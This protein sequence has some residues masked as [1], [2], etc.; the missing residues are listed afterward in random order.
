MAFQR[1]ILR[2]GF[3]ID[4]D[5][6]GFSCDLPRSAFINAIFIRLY[7]TGG[8]TGVALKDIITKVN[9]KAAAESETYMDLDADEIRLRTK[10]L[11]SLEP[12]VNDNDNADSWID[13]LLLFGRKIK[14]KR[15]MLDAAKHG[16]LQLS[17][18][19]GTLIDA[20]AFATG[21]VQ[22]D[23]ELIQWVGARPGEYAGCIKSTHWRTKPTGTGWEDIELPKGN[24]F[25][26]ISFV[27]GTATTINEV[28]FG[29]DNK[30]KT[31]FSSK[32]LNLLEQ[33]MLDYEW[34]TPETT[35]AI[36]DFCIEGASREGN[37]ANAMPVPKDHDFTL[38]IDR[39]V[40]TS[41][42]EVVVFEIVR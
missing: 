15:L 35:Q 32:F 9:I 28:I 1:T 33:N 41:T 30:T 22:I 38:H 2:S 31:P 8:A 27:V 12:T 11:L 4:D 17:L 7:G 5:A 29:I 37:L 19:F 10:Q 36:I 3:S 40:T 24:I 21:T 25:D 23:I 16:A 34:A 18:T 13:L 42:L 20:A 26:T 6:A 39:G 14:D